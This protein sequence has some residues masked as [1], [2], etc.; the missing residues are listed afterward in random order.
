MKSKWC[1]TPMP[2]AATKSNMAIFSIKVMVNVTRPMTLMS[3]ERVLLVEYACQIWLF[4][5]YSSKVIAKAQVFAKD[6]STDRQKL[7]TL[8]PWIPF[9]G[10]KILI[11]ETRISYNFWRQEKCC[12]T[13]EGRKAHSGSNSLMTSQNVNAK[14]SIKVTSSVHFRHTCTLQI[15]R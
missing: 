9:K 3:I 10:H 6:R 15:F 8:Y 2:Q 13:L 4:I 11:L 1:E 7:D 5:S 14:H 12:P